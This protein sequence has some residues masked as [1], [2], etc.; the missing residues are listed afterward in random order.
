MDITADKAK[1]WTRETNTWLK[2]RVLGQDRAVHG[3]AKALAHI[4]LNFGRASRPAGVLLIAGPTGVGK[5]HTIQMLAEMTLQ[6]EQD[7]S[8]FDMSKYDSSEA[9]EQLFGVTPEHQGNA[10]ISQL[11]AA[12]REAPISFIVFENLSAAHPPFFD[13]LSHIASTGMIRDYL[14]RKVRFKRTVFFLC[15]DSQEWVAPKAG[16]SDALVDFASQFVPPQLAARLD[17]VVPFTSLDREAL[18]SIVRLSIREFQQ[19]LNDPRP[20]FRIDKR[21]ISLLTDE[22]L[23]SGAGAGPLRQMISRRLFAP[24]ERRLAENK[25]GARLR[26]IAKLENVEIRVSIESAE[27]EV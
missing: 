17:C 23:T 15:F 7:L 12:T 1:Q 3:L 2:K 14:G 8:V 13:M 22:G 11:S 24:I 18:G 25:N 26:V 10:S 5:L 20:D 16:E 9:H 6:S 19:S 21:V 27:R 4:R